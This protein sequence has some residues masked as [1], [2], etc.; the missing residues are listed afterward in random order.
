[1][2]HSTDEVIEAMGD[3]RTFFAT[4]IESK[5]FSNLSRAHETNFKNAV[6]SIKA[7]ISPVII[8]NTH[9][10]ANEAKKIVVKALEL[11]LDE[12]MIRIED[13]GTNG[14]NAEA[15]A[16]RNTHG[17]PLEKIETMIQSHKSVGKLTV[18]KIIESKDMF[19]QSDI[20]FSAVVLDQASKT[21]L[22]ERF[23][24]LIP[25]DWKVITHHMTICLGELKDKSDIGK[26]VTLR[27][28]G[29]G[30][31]DMAM[32]A[33]VDGYNSLNDVPHITLAINPDGGMPKMSNEI[34]KWQDVKPFFVKG[35]VTE[36]SKSPKK[37]D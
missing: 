30:T 6:N 35:I 1:M 25:K 34:T 3:Y 5:D 26:E 9:I 2:I 19:K 20:L 23:D 28:F 37:D 27:V 11:G 31:T 13:I 24:M 14:L 36:I 16:N 15:L 10:K 4:M 7:G 22:L 17:V 18:K 29:V 33:K 21:I 12:N 8:D 32:A